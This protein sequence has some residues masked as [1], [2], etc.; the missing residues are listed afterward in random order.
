[1]G[2][3][4]I[5]NMYTMNNAI[6]NNELHVLYFLKKRLVIILVL[7]YFK[8]FIYKIDN[9]KVMRIRKVDCHVFFS[10]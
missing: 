8:M 3:D 7:L 5:R 9:Y 4:L 1:M 2:N 6:F 10:F